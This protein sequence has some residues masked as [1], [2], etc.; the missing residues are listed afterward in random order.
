MGIYMEYEAVSRRR[1]LPSQ[2]QAVC[3]N[4]AI[5]FSPGRE[6]WENRRT[7]FALKGRLIE[8][9]FQ[10]ATAETPFFPGLTPWAHMNCPFRAKNRT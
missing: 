1:E 7:R 8:A 2:E 9:L 10:S 4:G 6:P 5:H 3:A